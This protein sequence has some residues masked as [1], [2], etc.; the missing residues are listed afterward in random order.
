MYTLL[1]WK[2]STS[3]DVD[4]TTSTPSSKSSPPKML[5]LWDSGSR[6]SDQ[7]T[8]PRHSTPLP[9]P[10]RLLNETKNFT[11]NHTKIR[12]GWLLPKTHLWRCLRFCLGTR[13]T[14]RMTQAVVISSPHSPWGSPISK[15]MDLVFSCRV[16]FMRSAILLLS[17]FLGAVNCCSTPYCFKLAFRV[18]FTN[19]P[20][21]SDRRIFIFLPHCRS[22]SGSQV[23][24]ACF[25]CGLFAQPIDIDIQNVVNLC[26]FRLNQH[27]FPVTKTLF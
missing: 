2:L 18:I 11:L 21:P 9:T 16:R 10:L 17:G 6:V 13:V 5:T 27:I 23:R 8:L 25:D 19:F 15:I 3:R 14:F 4:A 26:K 22:A 1:Q 24:I 7:H 20:P 12:D